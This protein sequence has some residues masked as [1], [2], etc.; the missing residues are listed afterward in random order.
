MNKYISVLV[1][2]LV[3]GLNIVA[4]KTLAPS[5]PN[6]AIPTI[7][8]HGEKSDLPKVESLAQLKTLLSKAQKEGSGAW[9]SV[10]EEAATFG[11]T[12]RAGMADSATKNSMNVD[13]GTT[14]IQVQGVDEADT[15][16]TDGKYIYQIQE[17]QVV[18]SEVYPS[19]NMKV[20]KKLNFQSEFWPQEFYVDNQYLVVIGNSN[21][22]IPLTKEEQKKLYP[23]QGAEIEIYPPSRVRGMLKA[24]VYDISNKTKIKELRQVE[25]EGHYLSSR[26]IGS[27]VYFVAN[28]YVDYH[29]LEQGGDP[30]VPVYR[31]SNAGDELKQIA[32]QDICYFPEA[33]ELNYLMV[34]GIDLAKSDRKVEISTYLGAGQNIYASKDNLYVA[35]PQYEKPKQSDKKSE[36]DKPNTPVQSDQM[37]QSDSTSKIAIDIMPIRPANVDTAIYKFALQEGQIKYLTKGQVP[38]TI[39]NQFSMDEHNGYFRIATTKGDAWSTEQKSTNNVYILNSNLKQTGKIENIA[40]GE[41]IYSVRFMGEKGY[42]VTFKTVDPLFVIDLKDPN[43]PKILGSLKIPGY[44]DYLH[45]YDENHII[46]F[47]KET[48]EVKQKD[49]FGKEQPM[50]FYLGM[51]IALFDVSDVSKPKELFKEI[52]GGRGTDS[53]LLYNHKALLFSKEK[54]LLAFPITVMN[55]P[56]TMYDSAGFPQY[57]E[58]AFAGAYVYNLDLEKGFDLKGKI[59]HLNQSDYNRSGYGYDGGKQ[60]Q[61]LLYIEDDL[62]TVSPELI[63]AHDLTSL[64]EK[65]QLRTMKTK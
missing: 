63:K 27:T 45:P 12:Q 30:S 15:V 13:Y 55:T 61:R 1:F 47:G 53:E 56:K 8:E 38:G 24:I 57:G 41:R 36:I 11:T 9:G 44:S 64:K 17:Q 28:K 22:E 34:A 54:N 19:D 49:G 5:K 52:I 29:I 42:M 26:K 39:I 58:F 4:L 62:Y 46:G 14:N 65:G 7:S 16:K 31:D 20:V 25:L 21:E 59:S 60:I 35:V 10:R 2:V 51:K 3:I 37:D 50:A 40:P 43:A 32:Y 23:D 18:I 33:V 6:P 48:V